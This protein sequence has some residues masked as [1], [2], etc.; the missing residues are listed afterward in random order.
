MPNGL[1]QPVRV[2]IGP[3]KRRFNDL[4]T[5]LLVTIP[6]LM[7]HVGHSTRKNAVPFRL[8]GIRR[9]L[10]Q[11]AARRVSDGLVVHEFANE[12]VRCLWI[13]RRPFLAQDHG[14]SIVEERDVPV[15]DVS[16]NGHKFLGSSTIPRAVYVSS[17]LVKEEAADDVPA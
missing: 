5:E 14:S 17:N 7:A 6:I 8:P 11:D 2:G 1:A 15:G 16:P 10:M 4:A 13:G 3:L 12:P 9:K